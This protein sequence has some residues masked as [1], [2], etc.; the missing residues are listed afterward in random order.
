MASI[1]L[2]HWTI[3]RRGTF[4]TFP[5]IAAEARRLQQFCHSDQSRRSSLCPCSFTDPTSRPVVQQRVDTT[6]LS[7][8]LR[9]LESS[10]HLLYKMLGRSQL[11][12]SSWNIGSVSFNGSN[13]KGIY[14][15]SVTGQ[16]IIGTD[17]FRRFHQSQ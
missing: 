16:C 12:M 1:G 7:T 6:F 11:L 13:V 15:R 4:S 8:N 2:C 17:L 5:P 3:D 14:R 10:P 9:T